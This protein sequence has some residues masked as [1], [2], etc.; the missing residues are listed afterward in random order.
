MK[1]LRI[2]IVTPA[3]PGSRHGNRNTAERWAR[4][5]RALGHETQVALEWDGRD[6]DIL[7]ALHARRSHAAIHAWKAAHPRRPLALVLTGTDL[8]RDI[9]RDAKARAFMRAEPRYRWLGELDH[10]GTMRW[11]SRSHVMVISS[12][13]EGLACRAGGRGEGAT[14]RRRSGGRAR[15]YCPIDRRFVAWQRIATKL[16]IFL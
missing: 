1:P 16:N 12:R 11:L 7:I 4:H 2:V 10:A 8:Y 9:R 15:G 14:S 3:A 5:L 6:C 13:M